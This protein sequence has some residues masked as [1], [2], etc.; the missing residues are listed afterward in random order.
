[1][2]FDKSTELYLTPHQHGVRITS[3]ARVPVTSNS[4]TVGQ[5]LDYPCNV[6][7]LDLESAI[8]HINDSSVETCGFDSA[9]GLIGQSVR[10]VLARDDAAIS[11]SDDQDVLRHQRIKLYE[12]SMVVQHI[13]RMA[14]ISVKAP[15]LNDLNKLIGIFGCTVILGKQTLPVALQLMNALGLIRAGCNDHAIE[16]TY[17][18]WNPFTSR[19]TEILRHLA[20]G[21]SAKIIADRLSISRRT[22]EHHVENMK[23]KVN[24]TSR[25]ELIEM[26]SSGRS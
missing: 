5:A 11:M 25:Y 15:I 13:N 16:K 10:K 19:E 14:C 4:L 12:H 24:C 2:V 20:C 1:M 7:L 6:Y 3:A 9:S 8:Q 26:Y 23:A 21:M 17:S 22:V 18:H